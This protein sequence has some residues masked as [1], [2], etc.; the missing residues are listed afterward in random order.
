MRNEAFTILQDTDNITTKLY[1][2]FESDSL[3]FGVYDI[4]LQAYPEGDTLNFNVD[5]NSS[6]EGA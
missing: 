5:N 4:V 1:G 3:D 6:E 2:H